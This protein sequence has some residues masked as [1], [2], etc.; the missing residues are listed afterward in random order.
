MWWGEAKTE[1]K[2]KYRF[3]V[4]I[5]SKAYYT[6][7]SV[8]K[9]KLTF[10][11]KEYKMINHFYKYPGLGKW[12]DVDITFVDNIKSETS[13][14]FTSLVES[15]GFANPDGKGVGGTPGGSGTASKSTS[16]AALGKITITQVDGNGAPVE[17]WTLYDAILKDVSWGDTLSYSEDEL[18]EYKLTIQYDYAQI[19][20]DAIT[21]FT[22]SK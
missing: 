13:E 3:I 7:K 16:N 21:T 18:V 6:V 5:N 9:P 14:F 19:G 11:N 22:I 4:A 8:T 12:D 20:G 15:S 10:D 1:P 2:R 17:V